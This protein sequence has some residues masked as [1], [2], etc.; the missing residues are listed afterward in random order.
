[1]LIVLPLAVAALAALALRHAGRGPSRRS[2][3]LI[4]ALAMGSRLVAT[5]V[6]FLIARVA[7]EQGVWL[8]D[9]ASF[10]LATESLLPNPLDKPLPLGLGHLGGDGYLG[11]TTLLA[12]LVGRAD[13]NVFRVVNNAVGAMAVVLSML[14]S[15]RLFGIRAAVIS[16]LVLAVWPPLVLWS[17]TML[18]DTLGGFAVV[19]T[20][21]TIGRARDLG[22]VRTSAVVFFSVALTLSLRPYLAGAILV[23]V[24]AWAV[25]P[26]LMRLPKPALAALAALVA[27][28][29][30]A[31]VVAEARPIDYAAHQLLYRQTVTRME[32]LGLLYTDDPPETPD[33]PYKPGTAVAIADPST[34]WLSTG[35]LQGFPEADSVQVAFTDQ[36]VRDVPIGDVQMLQSTKIPPLQMVA[37]VAPNLVAYLTGSAMTG[38]TSSPAW[39][40]SSLAWDAVLLLALGGM[41][42]A[43][44]GIR[45]WLFPLCVVG[46]TALALIAIPGAPGNADRHRTTQTL[47]LLVVLASGLAAA[48]VTSSSSG[49]AVINATTSPPSVAAP[50]I[51]RMRSA[52]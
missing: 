8:N 34:G 41:V 3:L 1:M 11:L 22:V 50:A 46:G 6:I 47:P 13:S 44:L 4:A 52:R 31:F 2:V 40:L 28:G 43:R 27:V 16:G 30:V 7:H 23:G 26:V 19:A 29:G 24:A 39:T 18:R 32:T 25:Y 36:T 10:F 48:R 21:W 20:W 49:R 12:M 33:L 37:W 14:V 5:V 42:R 51:S 17:A 15:R 35:V 9:E 45:E 38:D